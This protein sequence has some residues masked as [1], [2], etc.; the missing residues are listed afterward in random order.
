M[1]AFQHQKQECSDNVLQLHSW[2]TIT[3][4]RTQALFRSNS[5]LFEELTVPHLAR[6]FFTFEEPGRSF[7]C[8]QYPATGAFFDPV[9]SSPDI[10]VQFT[11]SDPVSLQICCN[12][13]L[14]SVLLLLR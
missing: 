8:L 9:Q 7:P 3:Y 6:K 2:E 11:L 13:F 1:G 14:P 12:I 10:P 4:A 5:V